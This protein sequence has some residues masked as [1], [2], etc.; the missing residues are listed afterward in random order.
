M[1]RWTWALLFL[2]RRRWAHR[3]A[4]VDAQLGRE[5]HELGQVAQARAAIGAAR[6]AFL[7]D[8]LERDLEYWRIPNYGPSAGF[9]LH[10]IQEHGKA[11]GGGYEWQRYRKFFRDY[12]KRAVDDGLRQRSLVTVRTDRR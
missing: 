6:R 5:R 7:G 12:R 4:V 3:R 9:F 8:Y 10:F 2:R 1:L 11:A